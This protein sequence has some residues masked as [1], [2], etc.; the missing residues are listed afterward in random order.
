MLGHRCRNVLLLGSQ[1]L[2]HGL[3]FGVATG[4]ELLYSVAGI[5]VPARLQVGSNSWMSCGAQVCNRS[6]T[7]AVI[8]RLARLPVPGRVRRACA[9]RLACIGRQ[10][11]SARLRVRPAGG[12]RDEFLVQS[13]CTGPYR[14]RRPSRITRGSHRTFAPD[15]PGTSHGGRT[16]GP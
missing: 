4:C 5:G 2:S 8:G 9:L 16:P 11:T 14:H 7:V 10:R 12:D 6:V 3:R 13:G 1:D 15:T